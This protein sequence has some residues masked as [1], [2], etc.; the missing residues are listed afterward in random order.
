MM[1][2]TSTFALA[3]SLTLMSLGAHAAAPSNWPAGAREGFI[4][5]CST[6]AQQS[7]DAKTA[8]DHCECGA[9]KINAELST[10]EI[11]ELMTNQNASPELKNK[12]VAAI[13][14]CKVVKKK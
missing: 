9:D 11:K 10:A 2:F 4:K 12:A 8:K 3:A 5:D 1:R 13:S 6:A 7:V 14:S